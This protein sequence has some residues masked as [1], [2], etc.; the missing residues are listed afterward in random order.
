MQAY[1]GPDMNE[2]EY[3]YNELNPC[4][5]THSCVNVV[6]ILLLLPIHDHVDV[7]LRN[8]YGHE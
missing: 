8:D 2:L 1:Q 5:R 4:A 6:P 3:D 7:K